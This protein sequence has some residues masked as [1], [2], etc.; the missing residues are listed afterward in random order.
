V[1]VN[2]ETAMQVGLT[3]QSVADNLLISLA[4]S[5]QAVLSH[6][7]DPKSG[8]VYGVNVQTP[9]YKLNSP[10]ALLNTPLAGNSQNPELL[11]NVA[12]LDHTGSDLVISHYNIQPV[13]D[14]MAT[15]QNRD[16]GGVSSDI[17]EI[18]TQTTKSLPHGSFV[19]VRGQVATMNQSFANLGLGLIGSVILIYLLLTVNFQSWVDPIVVVS[20]VPCTLG[21]ILWMLYITQTT[22]NVPSLMGCIMAIG[23]STAN[24]I[25]LVTFANERRLDG[26]DA[27]HAAISAGAARLRPILMTAFAMIIGMVPMALAI[28]EGSEQNAPLGRAVIGGL[29]V[30][31]FTTL[32]FVP[33]VYVFLRRNQPAPEPDLDE[34]TGDN[35]KRAEAA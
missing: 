10:D 9:Q 17:I 4:G 21:G 24:S 3:Q 23:V 28:G 29:T 13:Y 27:V 1:N 34:E 30:A 33:I 2:R 14:I 25:L 16:L 22:L 18:L 5:G 8:V 20:G 35:E 15:T 11:S 12:T 7:L 19:A 26:M 32:F 6:W 31:T